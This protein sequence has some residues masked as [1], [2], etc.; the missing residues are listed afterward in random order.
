MVENIGVYKINI[1]L[2]KI[3]KLLTQNIYIEYK[4]IYVY[5]LYIYLV[6]G[7]LSC[8]KV[9]IIDNPNNSIFHRLHKMTII[10]SEML[11]CHSSSIQQIDLEKKINEVKFL[12][13]EM[14]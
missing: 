2:D 5:I 10:K 7:L 6:S 3:Y 12:V 4:Y 8:I 13:S 9:K 11:K 14:H 1:N